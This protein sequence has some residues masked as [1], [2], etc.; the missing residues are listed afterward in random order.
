MD[1]YLDVLKKYAVFTGRAGRRE[2]WMFF[3]FNIII[4]LVLNLGASFISN[5]LQFIP[6]LY[7]LA[8]FLPSLGVSIR[9]LHDTG[10]SGW[11]LLLSLI[12]VIGGLIVLYFMIQDSEPGDNAYGPNPNTTSLAGF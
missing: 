2:Y 9:R 3:L 5:N 8:V 1:P 6:V 4:S 7:S 11:M 10:R 12:P